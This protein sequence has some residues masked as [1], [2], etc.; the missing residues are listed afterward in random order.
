MEP[1]IEPDSQSN[2]SN[3]VCISEKSLNSVARRKGLPV[4][5]ETLPCQMHP[6]FQVWRRLLDLVPCSLATKAHILP[7]SAQRFSRMEPE[8]SHENINVQNKKSPF[9]YYVVWVTL[10]RRLQHLSPT[11]TQRNVGKRSYKLW[12]LLLKYLVLL[13]R[14][15]P[16]KPEIRGTGGW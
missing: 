8:P 7:A 6:S 1:S 15:D 2:L 13:Q 10:M 12:T 14:S 16:N 11:A 4:D 9:F 5:A 3:K